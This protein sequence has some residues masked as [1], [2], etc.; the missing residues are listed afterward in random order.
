[1]GSVELLAPRRTAP[2]LAADLRRHQASSPVP[3]ARGHTYLARTLGCDECDR[4]VVLSVLLGAVADGETLAWR[5]LE[6][7][8]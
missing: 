4:A 3:A 2:P 6:R 5:V 8:E 7:C 1:M